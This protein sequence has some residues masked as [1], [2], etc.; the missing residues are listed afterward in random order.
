MSSILTSALIVW[1]SLANAQT[2]RPDFT[3]AWGNFSE[4]R[5][6]RASALPP[7]EMQLN[8]AGRSARQDFLSVTEGTNHGAGNSCLGSGTPESTLYAETLLHNCLAV[9]GRPGAL[10][11]AILLDCASELS[12][13]PSS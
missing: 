12:A 9:H 7:G 5:I 6:D 13:Q 3:G 4:E 11:A 2:A 1:S 10:S 8:A